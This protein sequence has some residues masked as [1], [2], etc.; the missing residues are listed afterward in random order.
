[1]RALAVTLDLDGP[2]EYT[3]LHGLERDFAHVDPLAM[4]RQPLRRFVHLCEQ[5]GGRGTLFVIGRDLVADVG[6]TLAGYQRRGFEVASHSFGHDY[7]LSR[8]SCAAIH[9]DIR[10]ARL[11]IADAVGQMP[12]GFRGPGYHSSPAVLD[13]LEQEGFSY[14]SSMLPSP[15]YYAVKAV[16][17]GAYWVAGKATQSLL[18]SPRIAM[19]PRRPYHPGQS[20][21][22]PGGRAIWELPIAVAT[23]IRLPLTGA[24]LV[25]A[26]GLLRSALV[27]GVAHAD[28]VVVN[29]HALDLADIHS[30][31]LPTAFLRYQPELRLPWRERERRLL[32][33]LGQI[34]TG[35]EI[36]TA[37]EIAARL[38]LGSPAPEAGAAE[39]A[40]G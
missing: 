33:T 24:L 35:R 18:G 20:P 30:E 34:A 31:G 11:A 26:P 3:R 22:M 29:L 23:P 2:A 38:H 15:P 9:A 10:R 37:A 16:V 21:Y 12:R 14:S 40:P 19:G 28:I 25:L 8:R 4:Y 5:L 17:L 39:G 7:R 13:A 1:V 6:S 27:D 36:L 32:A